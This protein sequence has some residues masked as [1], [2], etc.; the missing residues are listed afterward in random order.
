M[1]K[2]FEPINEENYIFEFE[3][4]GMKLVFGKRGKNEDKKIIDLNFNT[5]FISDLFNKFKNWL[6]GLFSDN[7]EEVTEE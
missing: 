7:K 5:N 2:T 1:E 4:F 6:N 3:L